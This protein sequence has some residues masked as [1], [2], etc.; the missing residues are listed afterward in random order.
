[1]IALVISL[2]I[3]GLFSIIFFFTGWF[4]LAISYIFRLVHAHHKK[5]RRDQRPT[6]IFLIR[7]GESQANVDHSISF[8]I[9]FI[10]KII[11]FF[12]VIS[13]MFTNR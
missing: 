11:I 6:R 8:S 12:C 1:M 7:H 2:V 5:I 10:H 13:F 4:G 9:I 3:L